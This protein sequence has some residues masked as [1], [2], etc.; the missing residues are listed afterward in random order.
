MMWSAWTGAWKLFDSDPEQFYREYH[1]RSKVEAT[2]SALKRLMPVELRAKMF[3]GDVNEVLSKPGAYNLIGSA[4]QMRMRGMR[5]T[6][7]EELSSLGEE[8][9]GV[10][11]VP[12]LEAA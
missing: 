7:L 11:G 4:R 2:T 8:V 3:G 12:E 10:V 5:P 6:F 9:R 1:L